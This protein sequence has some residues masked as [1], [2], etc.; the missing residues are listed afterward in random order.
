MNRKLLCLLSIALWAMLAMS[1]FAAETSQVI[2]FSGTI[3]GQPD[4]GVALRFRLF[5]ANTG[6]TFVFEEMQTVTVSGEAFSA[7]I[8]NG[9]TG[10][11]P[12]AIFANNLSLWIAWA[13]DS[14]PGTELGDRVAIPSAGFAHFALTPAGPTGP[15]GLPGPPGL[16]GATGSMGPQ[17]LQGLPGPQGPTG[18]GITPGSTL[19]GSTANP[20]LSLTNTTGVGLVGKGSNGVR[21][22]SPLS[23]GNGVVGIADNGANAYGVWGLSMSGFG[24]VGQGN[25]GGV[26]GTSNTPGGAG[27]SAQGSGPAGTALQI[28]NGA[29]KVTGAGL[30]TATAAFVVQ[31]PSAVNSIFI[32][33]PLT[34]NDC[35]AILIVTPR[36]VEGSSSAKPVFVVCRLRAGGAHKWAIST[37]DFSAFGSTDMYYNVLVIKP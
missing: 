17:G 37:I 2:P 30:N 24:V 7:S 13:L 11:I 29:I 16:P 9:T 4:G 12:A 26:F 19:T 36:A 10:G 20:L 27:V 6:G 28:T 35:N 32:D 1:A 15:Q 22:E 33:N 8:G 25:R 31:A 34:N 18:P 14:D 23:G 5:S 21:G 3:P